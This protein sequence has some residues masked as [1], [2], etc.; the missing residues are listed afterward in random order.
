MPRIFTLNCRDVGVD[1][2][3]QTSGTTIEEVIERCAEHGQSNHGMKSFT[4]ELYARMRRFI[5]T[6]EALP[7][8]PQSPRGP[9]GA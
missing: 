4:P 3:F 6:E 9:G 7:H 8:S 1:C 2:D 5:K